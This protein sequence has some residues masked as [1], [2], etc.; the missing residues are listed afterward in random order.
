MSE[1]AVCCSPVSDPEFLVNTVYLLW[2][3]VTYDSRDGQIQYTDI[4]QV[5]TPWLIFVKK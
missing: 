4:V 3:R 5:S 2:A 1:K